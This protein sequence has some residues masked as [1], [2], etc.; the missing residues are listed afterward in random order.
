MDTIDFTAFTRAQWERNCQLAACII[1]VYEFIFQFPNEVQLFW[2]RRWTFAKCLFIWSRYYALL[3]SIEARRSTFTLS[4]F[5]QDRASPT[6][7]P[8]TLTHL[9]GETFF[10]IQNPGAVIQYITPQVTLCLRLYAMYG[11]S[12]KLLAFLVTLVL[13]EFAGMI[14]LLVLPKEG[15]VGTNNPSALLFICAD[16]D[17]PGEHWIAYVPVLTLV[18]ESCFLSLAVFKA[19]QQWR[20]GIRGGHLLPQLTKESVLFFTAIVAVH[21]ANLIIWL[22]NTIETNEMFTG[23]TFA[24]PAVL[25]NRLLISVRQQ[26]DP[27]MSSLTTSEYPVRLPTRANQKSSQGISSELEMQTIRTGHQDF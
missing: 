7:Y 26:I 5:I 18:T 27:G 12:K 13:G 23:F 6:L 1:V 20:I 21:L 22:F 4:V 17:P 24:V 10:K 11:R 14:V 2:K 19:W 15:V 8:R 3:F 9:A 16:A 25:A